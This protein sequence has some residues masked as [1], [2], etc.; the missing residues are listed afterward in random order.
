MRRSITINGQTRGESKDVTCVML[1]NLSLYASELFFLTCTLVLV[2]TSVRGCNSSFF[3]QL[4]L[5]GVTKSKRMW[6][7]RIGSSFS[8]VSLPPPALSSDLSGNQSN[9]KRRGAHP[10]SEGRV[11][12]SLF[13]LSPN[14]H[15][16]KYGVTVMNSSPIFSPGVQTALILCSTSS[17]VGT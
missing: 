13:C 12:W 6:T 4:N 16:L 8:V 15:G 5:K 14:H 7:P 10:W 17:T 1:A 9:V 3:L 11:L 2:M